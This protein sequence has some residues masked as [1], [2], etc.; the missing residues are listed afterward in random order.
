M[1]AKNAAWTSKHGK[2]VEESRSTGL[3]DR[4]ILLTLL[5]TGVRASELCDLRIFDYDL[6][7][8]R[9]HVR[10]G[11]GDK[12]RYVWAGEATRKA[13]WRFLASRPDAKPEHP[14]FP[15]RTDQPL[16]RS[17]LLK[18]ISACAKR[19]GVIAA[20]VHKFR[21]TFAITFLRNG[22][23]VLELQ[24]LLGHERVDTLKIYVTLAES[25]LSAAQRR[26]SPADNWKL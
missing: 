7:T 4:A 18:M 1:I 12:S 24:R 19:A 2:Y 20:N 14:L 21:H 13:I 26:A 15:T 25:D 8:G 3:R 11:K 22:G 23:T 9:L 17:N 6:K 10:K 16:D 5:D